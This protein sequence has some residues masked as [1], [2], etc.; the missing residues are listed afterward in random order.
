M[1]TVVRAS[2]EPIDVDLWVRQYVAYVLASRG[3]I[4]QGAATSHLPR[5]S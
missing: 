1:V 3:I 5:A 4:V 2:E